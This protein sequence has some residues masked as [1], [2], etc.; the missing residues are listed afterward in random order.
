MDCRLST[1]AREVNAGVE[2]QLF[3]RAPS[4]PGKINGDLYLPLPDPESKRN[5]PGLRLRSAMV[6]DKI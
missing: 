6:L 4:R 2:R 1:L 5:L 3:Q